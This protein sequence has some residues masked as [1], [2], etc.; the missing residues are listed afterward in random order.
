MKILLRL[1]AMLT[2]AVMTFCCSCASSPDKNRSDKKVNQTSP[3]LSC[4]DMAVEAPLGETIYDYV[5]NGSH[6]ICSISFTPDSLYSWSYVKDTG[7]E[8]RYSYVDVTAASLKDIDSAKTEPSEYNVDVAAGSKRHETV[9]FV[10]SIN[11]DPK[12]KNRTYT[13][14][15]GDNHVENFDIHTLNIPT[16]SIEVSKKMV[17]QI[18]S[19]LKK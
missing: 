3:M 14:N 7:E 10:K 5:D 12:F 8:S 18:K 19:R 16:Y 15:S 11:E 17:E 9:F 4:S 1:P 2:A 6:Y 13:C